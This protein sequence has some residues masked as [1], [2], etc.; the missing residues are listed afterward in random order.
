MYFHWLKGQFPM[1]LRTILIYFSIEM[2]QLRWRA[3]TTTIWYRIDFGER[4]RMKRY[5]ISN[6]YTNLSI[7]FLNTFAR[8]LRSI[9]YMVNWIE[10]QQE[11]TQFLICFLASDLVACAESVSEFTVFHRNTIQCS[12][13]SNLIQTNAVFFVSQ[14]K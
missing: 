4:G 10:L 2:L 11:T 6:L 7:T 1:R 12:H 14:I 9:V 5:F 13:N 8:K 3:A